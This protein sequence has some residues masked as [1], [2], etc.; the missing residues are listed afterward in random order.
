V[1]QV[2]ASKGKATRADPVAQLYEQGRIG[3]CGFFDELENQMCQ[4]TPDFDASVAGYSPD[5][6]DAVVWGF[7]Y[8]FLG[9]EEAPEVSP[10]VEVGV[11]HWSGDA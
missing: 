7:S 10:L 6:V 8:L 5:R 3:H 2:K 4:M 11:S 9:A 1:K